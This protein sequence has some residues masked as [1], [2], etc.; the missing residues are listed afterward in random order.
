M[1]NNHR[2]NARE[3]QK[4]YRSLSKLGALALIAQF[5]R[6]D[7]EC[8]FKQPSYN[9]CAVW[10]QGIGYRNETKTGG[11]DNIS[12]MGG[13]PLVMKVSGGIDMNAAANTIGVVSQNIPQAQFIMPRMSGRC[14]R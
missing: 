8:K 11:I 1:T 4:I 14:L 2:C 3:N 12:L 9:F 13:V 10:F 5:A 6:A 7:V